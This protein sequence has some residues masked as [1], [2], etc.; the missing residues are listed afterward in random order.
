MIGSSTVLEAVLNGGV[1]SLNCL[2]R[3]GEIAA[4]D[5]IKVVFLYLGFHFILRLVMKL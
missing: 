5:C 3:E 2:L 4:S 1:T